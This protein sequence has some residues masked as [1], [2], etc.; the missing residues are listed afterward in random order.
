MAMAWETYDL[1]SALHSAKFSVKTLV[2]IEHIQ[3]T[4][5][6]LKITTLIPFWFCKSLKGFL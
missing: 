5:V 1:G 6:S 4:T 2:R 3:Q